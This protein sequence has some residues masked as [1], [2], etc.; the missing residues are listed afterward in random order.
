MY[1][2]VAAVSGKSTRMFSVARLYEKVDVFRTVGELQMVVARR[3]CI[4]C[5]YG[6]GWRPY[7]CGDIFWW[8]G[9][10]FCINVIYM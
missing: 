7:R 6:S 8:G 3:M 10:V 4:M 2:N 9:V 1:D 5:F